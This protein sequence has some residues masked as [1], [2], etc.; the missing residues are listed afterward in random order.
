MDLCSRTEFLSGLTTFSATEMRTYTIFFA[1]LDLRLPS[2]PPIRH[3][4]LNSQLLYIHNMEV[5]RATLKEI[6]LQRRKQS[7][8]TSCRRMSI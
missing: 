2:S 8:N 6:G 7:P 3:L 1:Q 4:I 5:K